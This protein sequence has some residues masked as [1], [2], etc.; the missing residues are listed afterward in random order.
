V[1]TFVLKRAKV[2]FLNFDFG[3]ATLPNPSTDSYRKSL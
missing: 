2:H 1:Q 3:R